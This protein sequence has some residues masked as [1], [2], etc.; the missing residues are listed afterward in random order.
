MARVLLIGLPDSSGR[1]LAALLKSR[2]HDV[3]RLVRGQ[4]Q[5]RIRLHGI[6]KKERL[7][8]KISKI[9][10]PLFI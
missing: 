3:V 1:P 2:G 5:G 4:R 8:K 7:L 9:L 6:L 10:T